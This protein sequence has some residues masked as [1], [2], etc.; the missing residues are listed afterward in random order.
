MK[1]EVK[2]GL[3]KLD[4]ERSAASKYTLLFHT[5]MIVKRLGTVGLSL[6]AL[7]F[8]QKM[9]KYHHS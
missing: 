5:P 4:I 6:I 8:Q 1:I 9:L 3:G 7:V 2:E